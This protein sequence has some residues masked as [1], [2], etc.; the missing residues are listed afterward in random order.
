MQTHVFGVWLEQRRGHT[1]V[2][3]K[4]TQWFVVHSS[5]ERCPTQV[6]FAARS[7][8]ILVFRQPTGCLRCPTRRYTLPILSAPKPTHCLAIL[9]RSLST[10]HCGLGST[11]SLTSRAPSTSSAVASKGKGPVVS[12]APYRRVKFPKGSSKEPLVAVK[13][14]IADPSGPVMSSLNTCA[15]FV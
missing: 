7:G 9:R 3:S 2:W 1:L 10:F 4:L 5:S 15:D 12:F 8:R 11:I 13:T 14:S 6:N